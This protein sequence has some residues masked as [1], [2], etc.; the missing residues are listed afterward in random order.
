MLFRPPRV[1]NPWLPS[2]P[3]YSLLDA[4]VSELLTDPLTDPF[5]TRATNGDVTPAGLRQIFGG[6]VLAFL[7]GL[8][9]LSFT[10]SP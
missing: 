7:V 8:K 5:C 1:F 2:H 9:A 4:D 6:V 10:V 3:C